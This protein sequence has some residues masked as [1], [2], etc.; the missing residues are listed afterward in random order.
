MKKTSLW[1]FI[2]LLLLLACGERIKLPTDIAP[3]GPGIPD[4]T[5]VPISPAWTEAGGIPYIGP[6]DVHVGFDGY[7]YI[8]ATGQ[9]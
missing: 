3:S 9:K 6:E 8:T 2:L 1:I 7:L 4:T 5:Y